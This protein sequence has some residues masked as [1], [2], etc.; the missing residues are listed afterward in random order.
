MKT[1]LKWFRNSLPV[2]VAIGMCIPALAGN[3]NNNNNDNNGCSNLPDH[4]ALQAALTSGNRNRNQRPQQS[5]VGHHCR[6]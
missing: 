2:V 4:G 1:I 3:N 6:S 5:D